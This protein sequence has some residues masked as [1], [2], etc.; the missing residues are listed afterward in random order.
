MSRGHSRNCYGMLN[1]YEI[2]FCAKPMNW[3]G[4]DLVVLRLGEGL[5]LASV[6]FSLV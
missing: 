5:G 6:G 3:A 2:E 1:F 4:L